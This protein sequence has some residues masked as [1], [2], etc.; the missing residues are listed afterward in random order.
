MER[1]LGAPEQERKEFLKAALRAHPDKGGTTADFLAA[2]E[3]YEE[4]SSAKQ[5]SQSF[6]ERKGPLSQEAVPE[7]GE[8]HLGAGCRCGEMA[9][10]S[11]QE[12]QEALREGA[13]E[14]QIECP[15]CSASVRLA[16]PSCSLPPA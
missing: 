11:Y 12:L 2:K 1:E 3:R 14:I 13:G 9:A 7:E 10:V 4:A 16:L 15:S 6:R 5:A 8:G